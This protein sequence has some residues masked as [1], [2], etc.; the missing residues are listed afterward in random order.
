MIKKG[1]EG[2]TAGIARVSQDKTGNITLY[3]DVNLSNVDVKKLFFSCNNFLQD[4]IGYQNLDGNISGH[5]SLNTAW[6]KT[7]EFIPSSVISQS[8][9]VLSNGEIKDYEPLMGL[10][11]FIKVEELKDIKFE[12]LFANISIHHEK[13]YLDKTRVVSSALSFDCSGVHG[14]D[15]KYEYRLQLAL[16]DFLWKK[17]KTKNI[18]ITEFGYVV[19]DNTE[20]TIV[21]V[22]IVGNG[23]EFD[24]KYDKRTARNRFKDKIEQ[25][26]FELKE[27]F[28]TSQLQNE[29]QQTNNSES[30]KTTP[31]KL[32][33]T[34]SGKYRT[35]S[36]DYILEWDDS[37][38]NGSGND[39]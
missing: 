30:E 7:L 10:S 5:V 36:N 37:E 1:F 27:L 23:T 32:E 4:F 34:D 3:T 33:K 31:V 24:V 14:F 11:K 25:E 8:E 15:N 2:S 35:R 39:Y 13:V 20:Q 21:P 19:D 6:T 16:S 29:N 28:S 17:T 9:V 38:D 12:N 22:I 18:E 26:K